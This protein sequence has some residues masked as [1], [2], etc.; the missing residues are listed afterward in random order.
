MQKVKGKILYLKNYDLKNW[1]EMKY[2][3]Y[4]DTGFDVR[5]CIDEDSIILLP[6]ERKL[7]PLGFKLAL[8][9]GYGYQIRCRSG[10]A[11]REGLSMVN[12]IGT[13]DN[14]YRGE[15]QMI[16]INLGERPIKIERG[17]R[18]GQ[19]IIEPVYQIEMEIVEKEEEL[20]KSVREEG[21]GS[22]GLK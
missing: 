18:I 16:A 7:I 6:R 3:Y 20:G 4:N 11:I 14:G 19:C 15:V 5:A 1:G 8:E 13:I 12:G 9:E 10:L 17:M 21:F 2:A 22:S